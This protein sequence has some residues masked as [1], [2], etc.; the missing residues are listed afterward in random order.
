MGKQGT[1]QSFA[2]DLV[3]DAG[4]LIALERGDRRVR[5]LVKKG[6]FAGQVV[7]PT[8]VLAQVWRG[9]P[10][11]AYL[12]MLIDASDVDSLGESRAKEVGIR[13]GV[14]HA[15]DIADAHVVCC[16][17]ERHAA[18]ATS[19]PEDLARLAETGGSLSLIPV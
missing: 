4:A 11:S 9:G 7:V 13:L 8:T 2:G 12:A 15:T 17:S 16:A 10:R 14:R 18:V 6:G 1:E 5:A 19:D 3:L